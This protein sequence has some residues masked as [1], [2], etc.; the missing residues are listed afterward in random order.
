[1][2]RRFFM[3]LG[4][5]RKLPDMAVFE[6][7]RWHRTDWDSCGHIVPRDWGESK[8]N[9]LHLHRPRKSDFGHTADQLLVARGSNRS[10]S[11]HGFGCSG[12]GRMCRSVTPHPPPSLPR[13]VRGPKA[14]TWHSPAS[15][16]HLSQA[17]CSPSP[18]PP[19][20]SPLWREVLPRTR[21]QRQSFD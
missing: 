10:L 15:S 11:Q 13:S 4:N 2:N 8:P 17:V 7:H 3:V 1:M 12:V 21:K 16:R 6:C 14:R 19:S 18:Y 20:D 5:F 9:C